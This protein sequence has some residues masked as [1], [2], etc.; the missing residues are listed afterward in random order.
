[1]NETFDFAALWKAQK[2]QDPGGRLDSEVDLAFW[3]DYAPR[4]DDCV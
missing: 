4:Y 2:L 1:M 3:H